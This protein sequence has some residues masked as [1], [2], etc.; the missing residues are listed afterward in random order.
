LP[1]KKD[2]EPKSAPRPAW[3]GRWLVQGLTLL[4]LV[5]AV[6]GAIIWLGNWGQEQIRGRDRYA[7]AFADINCAPPAGMTRGEFLDEV[8]YLS[9]WPDRF[10][11][12]DEDV[13]E[14]LT[15]AFAKHPWVEKVEAVILEAP[16]HVEVRLVMRRPVLVVRTQEGPIAVDRHGVRLPKNAPVQYLPIFEGEAAPPKGPAG[17]RWGDPRVEER[18]RGAKNER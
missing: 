15:L 7:V 9:R 14:R 16:R 18:A 2:S 11:L 10:G 5:A 17:T 8:L 6:L 13:R 3:S 12:L 1:R 4:V